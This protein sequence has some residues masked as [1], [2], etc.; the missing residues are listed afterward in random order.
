MD[1]PA[2]SMALSQNKILTD[3]GVAMLSK[4]LDVMEDTGSSLVAG[5]DAVSEL[6]VNP[7]IGGNIDIRI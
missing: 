4:S 5:I 2:L 7:D 1:I 3:V 6:S